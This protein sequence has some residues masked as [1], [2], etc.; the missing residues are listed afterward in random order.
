MASFGGLDRRADEELV[1]V[2]LGA[3]RRA[4]FDRAS[5]ISMLL[6]SRRNYSKNSI[7]FFRIDAD[8]ARIIHNT[9]AFRAAITSN[10]SFTTQR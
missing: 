2:N 9:M 7:L 4:H 3:R 5:R 6:H 10:Y 1:S 8:I